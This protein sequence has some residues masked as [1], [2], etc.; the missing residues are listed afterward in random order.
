[1]GTRAWLANAASNTTIRF[2]EAIKSPRAYDSV[3]TDDGNGFADLK[4]RKYALLVTFRKNGEPVPTPVW[5][6]LADEKLYFRSVA[7]TAKLARIATQ[8]NVLVAPCTANGRPRGHAVPGA[9]RILSP[10]ECSIAERALRANYG[11]SRRIYM[12]TI[13]RHVAGTYVEV[14]PGA[15]HP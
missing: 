2:Y 7:T 8:P 12:R 1:M 4:G 10:D 15:S 5:F 6:G 11:L 3:T 13:A 14:R 9:A